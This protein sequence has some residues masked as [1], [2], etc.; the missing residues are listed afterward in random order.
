MVPSF[1]GN[2]CAQPRAIATIGGGLAF[3]NVEPGAQEAALLSIV[4]PLLRPVDLLAHGIDG[5]PNAPPALVASIGVASARLD[6]R[7]D[8]RAVEV[9]AHDAHPLAVAPVELAVLLIELDLLRRVRAAGRDDDPAIASVEIGALDRAVIRRGTEAH[10][11]PV[12]MAGLDVDR[13]AIR[14]MTVGDDDL[15]VGAVRPHRVDA[16]AAHLE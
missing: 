16:A 2:P 8:E 4:G 7:F 3:G 10:V 13:D 11:R 6:E 9:R 15:P 14:E 5:Y 12:D 1:F